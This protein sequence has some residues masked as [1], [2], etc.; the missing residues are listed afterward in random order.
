IALVDQHPLIHVAQ[1]DDAGKRRAH[2][3]VRQQVVEPGHVGLHG[4]GIVTGGRHGLFEGLH[5]G[6]L[7]SPLGLVGV[8]LLARNHAFLGQ[9]FPALGGDARQV[10][11]AAAL[12]ERGLGLLDGAVGL[13][14]GGL[15][16]ANL[17]VQF[18]SF[19]FGQN[20]PLFD[21]VA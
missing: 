14:D 19:D 9:V 10:L 5:I 16:L 11:I 4:G 21:A 7:G 8:V 6:L 20:L 17:L 2:G 13:V 3:L 1:R 18:G 15:G 12:L